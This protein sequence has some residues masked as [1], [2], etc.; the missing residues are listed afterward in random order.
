MHDLHFLHRDLSRR[1]VMLFVDKSCGLTLKICDFGCAVQ[2]CSG[3]PRHLDNVLRTTL[4]YAAPELLGQRLKRYTYTPASDVWSA[5]VLCMEML[6]EDS[7][8]YQ[9]IPPGE[10]FSDSPEQIVAGAQMM[11]QRLQDTT[12][13]M[14]H[15]AAHSGLVMCRKMLTLSPHTRCSVAEALSSPYLHPL[16]PMLV[17]GKG[18]AQEP[19]AITPRPSRGAGSIANAGAVEVIG[20]PSDGDSSVIAP[21]PDEV[22]AG[23]PQAPPTTTP[24]PPPPAATVA[25]GSAQQSAASSSLAGADQRD[26]IELHASLRLARVLKRAELLDDMFPCDISSFLDSTHHWGA[27]GDWAWELLACLIKL[28]TVID[29]FNKEMSKLPSD[30]K[31]AR[32]AS[33][34]M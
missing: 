25:R 8:V 2:L 3:S 22:L 16:A 7:R 6:S 1:N 20:P 14:T 28:P 26:Q 34:S 18:L 11:V 17:D 32:L 5:G 24:T 30:Y 29:I 33:R 27:S 13:E 15:S 21:D 19:T 23:A 31:A 9:A 12:A 10:I 4:P